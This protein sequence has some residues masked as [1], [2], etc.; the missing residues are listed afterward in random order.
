MG[1]VH[2]YSRDPAWQLRE[3][4][5]RERWQRSDWEAALS[6]RKGSRKSSGVRQATRNPAI[7]YSGARPQPLSERI[8]FGHTSKGSGSA[9]SIATFGLVVS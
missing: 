8:M 6:W 3:T 7:S 2:R 5:Q 9:A 1:K 4:S